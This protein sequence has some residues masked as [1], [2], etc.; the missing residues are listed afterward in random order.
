MTFRDVKCSLTIISHM[1][2]LEDVNKCKIFTMF[3][4]NFLR[5]KLKDNDYYSTKASLKMKGIKSSH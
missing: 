3:E 5:T 1:Q 2:G 4:N